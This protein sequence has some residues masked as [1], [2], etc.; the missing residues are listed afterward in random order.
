MKKGNSKKDIY[1]FANDDIKLL[2]EYINTYLHYE[3]D[4]YFIL[5]ELEELAYFMIDNIK[6]INYSLISSIVYDNNLLNRL[7]KN[8]ISNKEKLD[9]DNEIVE[10]MINAYEEGREDLEDYFYQNKYPIQNIDD[11]IVKKYM[12]VV[13]NLAK[14]WANLGNIP[15]NELI[16]EGLAYLFARI[17][18]NGEYLQNNRG[19]YSRIYVRIDYLLHQYAKNMAYPKTLAI[20]TLPDDTFLIDTEEDDIIRKTIDVWPLINVLSPREKEFF[21]YFFGFNN[22]DLTG[23]EL[24]KKNHISSTRVYQIINRGIAK[25]KGEEILENYIDF[26]DNPDEG[27]DLVKEYQRIRKIMY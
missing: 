20:S 7:L 5:E 19:T 13:F 25:I 12:D 4:T 22:N 6:D 23:E 3:E 11:K 26:L 1:P 8:I 2:N 21:N 16:E 17:Y 15:K 14:K 24:A 10:M 9:L 18:Q 27:K